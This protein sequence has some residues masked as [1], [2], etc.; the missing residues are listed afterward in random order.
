MSDLPTPFH[1]L[2]PQAK[3]AVMASLKWERDEL[4]HALEACV[5]RLIASQPPAGG[6]LKPSL[7]KP[8]LC[9]RKARG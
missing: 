9:W 1:A 4:R 7:T 8:K 6:E 2:T 5:E 3:D